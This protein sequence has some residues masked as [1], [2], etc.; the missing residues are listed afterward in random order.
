MDISDISEILEDLKSCA[1][2]EGRVN[3]KLTLIHGQIEDLKTD[4][5]RAQQ[6]IE[7][8]QEKRSQLILRLDT[9][10]NEGKGESHD[11]KRP[12]SKYLCVLYLFYLCVT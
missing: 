1:R 5:Q 2:K 3:E 6:E 8:I 11:N 7:G 10:I 12:R 4:F 9:L